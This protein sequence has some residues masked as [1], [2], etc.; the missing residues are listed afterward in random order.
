ML[1]GIACGFAAAISQSI[2]YLFTKRYTAR[3]PSGMLPLLAWGHIFMGGFSLLCL[4]LLCP[5]ALPP[6]AQWLPPL[7]LC[8]IFYLFGQ[9]AMFLAFR[10]SDASRLSPLLGLKVLFLSLFCWTMQGAHYGGLQW[11]AVGLAV[12]A[13]LALAGSGG[14]L[15]RRS[16][17]WIVLACLS[18]SV[19]DLFVRATVDHFR[20]LGD[21]R[22]AALSA[23]LCYVLCG[24]AGLALL[25][26]LAR[27][28]RQELLVI[29]PFSVFWFLAML[30]LFA[31]F[32]LIGVVY[33]NIVQSTRGLFSIALGLLV[34]AS[35]RH[36]LEI[37]VNGLILGQ[38]SFLLQ[39]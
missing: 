35:G 11:I 23:V 19:S 22:G 2:C 31:C 15:H 28:G 17:F 9:I 33:G 8:S 39:V 27:P 32:G 4:P 3:Y 30:L 5:A 29:L 26:F 18:Y 34:A 37:Q 20:F 38:R 6:L 16:L 24:L 36:H 12:L 14:R 1:A 10:D 13:A 7:A 21:F 25:P